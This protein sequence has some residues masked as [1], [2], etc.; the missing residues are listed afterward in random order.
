M[1]KLRIGS[2]QGFWGD[3]LEAP[4]QLVEKGQIDYLV[5]DYLAEVTMSILSKQKSR[6]PDHGFAKDFVDLIDRIAEDLIS[7]KVKVVSNAG[8]VNPWACARA[9]QEVLEKKGLK[10]KLKIAV[11]EG[12]DIFGRIDELVSSGESLEHLETGASITEVKDKIQSANVYLGCDPIVEALSKGAHI[13][14]AGR[15]AD[16]SMTLG[17]LMFEFA[18]SQQDLDCLASGIV[19]GH[20]IECG[21]QVTGGNSQAEWENIKDFSEIAYPIVEVFENGNFI[22]TKPDGTA[23]TVNFNTVR[24]QLVYEIGDPENYITPDVIADFTS[25]SLEDL[26]SDRVKVKDVKGKPK[27]EKLKV[28]ICYQDAY[29]AEGTLVYTWPKAYQKAKVA[30]ETVFKRLEKIGLSFDRK[31]VEYIGVNSCHEQLVKVEVDSVSE[32]MLRIAVG[33]RDLM[34]VKRFTR[35]MA[36]LVLNGPPSVAAYS[37][38]KRAVQEIF[39]YW[40]ALLSREHVEA[41]VSIV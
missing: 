21:A 5:L 17:P 30:A 9:I 25:L 11:I 19:A 29:K 32:V 28:S 13:I 18:W 36:P 6:N 3:W 23:G 26:G 31:R 4:V 10:D 15:L 12:D 38:G 1:K 37:G 34:K 14:V 2:G 7:K 40:P 27:P 41:K 35:E 8:G 33:D 39:A 20:L 24:E 16:P 22:I